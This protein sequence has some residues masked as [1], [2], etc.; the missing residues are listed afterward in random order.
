[1]KEIQAQT[2]H[3]RS[4][5]QV[6]SWQRMSQNV[7][8]QMFLHWPVG[9]VAL[10]WWWSKLHSW[11]PMVVSGGTPG[12]SHWGSRPLAPC[13]LEMVLSQCSWMLLEQPHVAAQ[14]SRQSKLHSTA[15]PEG[16]LGGPL[17]RTWPLVLGVSSE[18]ICSEQPYSSASSSHR[19][20]L[21]GTGRSQS[22]PRK[23]KSCPEGSTSR[24]G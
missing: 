22:A 8:W 23:G 16:M 13:W 1:M 10:H 3:W 17:L 6:P 7:G 19:C 2:S 24:R 11:M 15:A 4:R 20:T 5:P 12:G 18:K 14:H 9:A 21:S